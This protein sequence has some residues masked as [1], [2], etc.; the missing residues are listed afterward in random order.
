M[1]MKTASDSW[2]TRRIMKLTRFEKWFMN[3]PQHARHA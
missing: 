1:T 3:S 2:F